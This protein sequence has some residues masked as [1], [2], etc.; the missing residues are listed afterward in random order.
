MSNSDFG[1]ALLSKYEDVSVL[2]PGDSTY[3]EARQVYNRM[4]DLYPLMIIRTMNRSALREL[5]NFVAFN[6]IE[7]AI[8]GGGHHI[9]GFGSTQGGILLDF[10]PYK[11]VVIDEVKGIASIS[12]GARLSDVDLALCQ[13]GYVIPT[14]TVSDTGIA[15]LTLGG[16]I[17]WLLGTLGF[18]CENLVGADVLLATGNIVRAEDPGYEDLLWA[19]RGGGGNF[20]VVLEFRYTLSK[21]PTVYCGTIEVFDSDIKDVFNNLIVYLDKHCPPNLVVAPVLQY[22]GDKGG[23]RLSIDFCLCDSTDLLE[24]K[25]FEE[26]LGSTIKHV[27]MTNDYVSWQSW[28]DERF[29]QPMRGYWKSVC[30]EVM[31]ADISRLLLEWGEGMPGSNCNITIEHFNP[32]RRQQRPGESAFPLLDKEYGILF[33][34]RWTSLSDD[35]MYIGW[36][37]EAAD[38]IMHGRGYSSY[39]NYTSGEEKNSKLVFVS[40]EG[41]LLTTKKKYDPANMFRRNHNIARQQDVS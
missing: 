14:G 9:A 40:D 38:S 35:S 11:D 6:D 30:P 24:I 4:H 22:L 33:S 8:R 10:S 37:K 36:V 41:R 3:A 29:S 26:Y 27:F 28:S 21:L 1:N 2:F 16:G 39:S 20:G 7:L 17:G 23:C 25:T 18:T 32:S 12:P 31:G 13:R 5:V 34:A 15:G 19:L